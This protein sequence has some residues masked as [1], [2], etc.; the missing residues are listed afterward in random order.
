MLAVWNAIFL[1]PRKPPLS[2]RYSHA[3]TVTHSHIQAIGWGKERH[4]RHECE[5]WKAIKS[6]HAHTLALAHDTRYEDRDSNTIKV[7]SNNPF[8]HTH[9]PCIQ[10]I[11]NYWYLFRAFFTTASIGERK[12]RRWCWA[13][14][15]HWRC[16]VCRINFMFFHLLQQSRIDFIILFIN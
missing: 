13:C 15:R 10:S 7:Q 1:L 4:N 8:T 11:G 3:D 2:I 9:T 12:N 16:V 6:M 5:K 14:R